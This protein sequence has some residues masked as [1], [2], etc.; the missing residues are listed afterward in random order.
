MGT[1][2][3]PRLHEQQ[4]GTMPHRSRLKVVLF[5]TPSHQAQAGVDFWSAALGGQTGKTVSAS[6]PYAKVG[7]TSHAIDIEVQSIDGGPRVH[8]DIETDD[9]EAEVERL[10]ALGAVREQ[11]VERWW[12]MKAPSGHIFCV[13]PIQSDDFPNGAN[14]WK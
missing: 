5:D 12:V 3:W 2:S 4:V 14:A 6:D 1:G 9:I 7:N 8:V 11:K 13:V 10:E